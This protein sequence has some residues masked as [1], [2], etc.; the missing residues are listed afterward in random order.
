[1]RAVVNRLTQHVAKPS[2][3]VQVT[4][5]ILKN[6]QNGITKKQPNKLGTNDT[7]VPLRNPIPIS[8]DIFPTRSYACYME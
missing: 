3:V 7:T 1:M 8:F 4:K 2:V 6:E 5:N